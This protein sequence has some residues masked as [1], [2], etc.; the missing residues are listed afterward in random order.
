MLSDEFYAFAIAE[1]SILF[2][3]LYDY[4]KEGR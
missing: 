3:S 2:I 4:I 1:F